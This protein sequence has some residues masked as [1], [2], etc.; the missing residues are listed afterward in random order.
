MVGNIGFT[1]VKV[2]TDHVLKA[3]RSLA[4]VVKRTPL[5]AALKDICNRLAHRS[6]SSPQG[7]HAS[8]ATQAPD[9]NETGAG[10]SVDPEMSARVLDVLITHRVLNRPVRQQG[11]SLRD[12]VSLAMVDR[13]THNLLASSLVSKGVASSAKSIRDME[14]F[15][16][17]FDTVTALAPKQQTEPLSALGE[18]ILSLPKEDQLSAIRRFRQAVDNLDDSHRCGLL[19]MYEAA[20]KDNTVVF[21]DWKNQAIKLLKPMIL[22][23]DA[24]FSSNTRKVLADRY[25]LTD[26]WS[27]RQLDWLLMGSPAEDLVKKGQSVTEAIKTYDL[28]PAWYWHNF[29]SSL[30]RLE[31]FALDHGPALQRVREG[32]DYLE[33]AKEY[34]IT[35]R[36]VLEKMES[37]SRRALL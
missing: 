12:Q 19:G 32:M 21:A 7:G 37:E 30:E 28:G 3:V 26:D 34:G 25:G 6:S 10:K 33:V 23:T 36:L 24:K 4:S 14:E 15:G 27:L 8:A 1:N 20:K 5:A 13:A 31:W 17:Q 22:E 11:L 35:N 29:Q 18:R 9:V 2:T 16:R